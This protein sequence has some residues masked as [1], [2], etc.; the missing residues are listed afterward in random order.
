MHFLNE[1]VWIS[2]KIS[3]NKFLPKGPINNIPA[4]FQIMAWRQPD[5]KPLSETIMVSL[6]MHICVTRPQW[7][8]ELTIESLVFPEMVAVRR[9]GST[10]VVRPCVGNW[11]NWME[12]NT[13]RYRAIWGPLSTT[14][15]PMSAGGLWTVTDLE[16]SECQQKNLLCTSKIL[17]IMGHVTWWTFLELLCWYPIIFF[18]WLQLVSRPGIHGWPSTQ[19]NWIAHNLA[20]HHQAAHNP[21]ARWCAG[22]VVCNLSRQQC[23]LAQRRYYHLDVGPTLSQPTLLSDWHGCEEGYTHTHNRA[24]TPPSRWV[25]CSSVVCC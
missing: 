4:L 11:M 3:L 25:V 22:S 15:L 17:V 10:S 12:P 16:W 7:V 14:S 13:M 21:A 9:T 24:S 19:P 6:L 18:L 23:T 5:D 2:I 1:N 8:K 20:A